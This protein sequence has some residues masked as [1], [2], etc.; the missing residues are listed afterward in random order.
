MTFSRRIDKRK[1]LAGL[2]GILMTGAF[3]HVEIS[4]L[5]WV[6]LI[7]LLAALQGASLKEGFRIGFIAGLVHYLTL[8]YWLVYTLMTFGYLPL[9]LSLPI[10]L[11][12][13]GYMSLYPAI[14]GAACAGLFKQPVGCLAIL[15]AIWAALEYIRSFFL[16]GFPWEFL[17]HSQYRRI[18]LIQIADMFGVYGISFLIVAVNVS[19][20]LLW[21]YLAERKSPGAPAKRSAA[22][23]AMA[24]A[25]LL[26]IYSLAYGQWRIHLID[27]QTSLLPAPK[28]TVVQGNIDQAEKWDPAFQLST[29][30]KYLALSQSAASAGT[31]LIVW[32]ETAAPFY[33]LYTPVPTEMVIKGIQH[34][35]TAFLIG[36]PSFIRQNEHQTDFYNSAFLISPD[37]RVT[38][39]YD[40]VHLVPFGEYAPLQKWLP[41]IGKMI[42]DFQSGKEGVTLPW[43]A[44]TLGIQICYEMIFPEL[45]REMVR[46]H[47][48]F[49]IN[50]TNDA[51]YGTTSA[52]YQHFSM[53]VFRAVENHRSL[54]RSA[55]TGISGFI[56]P[57]G[58]ILATTRLFEDAVMTRAMPAIKTESVYTQYGDFF[59]LLCLGASGLIILFC[60]IRN[61]REI[62]LF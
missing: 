38:G 30:E 10:L 29:T 20:F 16:S 62:R 22:V 48:T 3:P 54:I 34:M 27:T 39:K 1:F 51:W 46:H 44:N 17:G 19:L 12:L 49:L 45:S 53:A 2:S 37:G 32:P 25:A 11:L 35:G 57:A 58:R 28:I 52:P 47:A 36:S 18:Y 33:F 60:M 43:E 55:N 21:R 31:D 15:P 42:D 23:A 50:M 7:P 9:Y 41:F 4:W 24:T 5:A 26:V 40:K 13:T 61:K 6:S 56:D 8:M 59:S 14:F